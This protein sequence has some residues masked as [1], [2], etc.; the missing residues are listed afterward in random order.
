M[1]DTFNSKYP[2]YVY[3]RRPNNSRKKRRTEGGVNR[4]VD[5]HLTHEHGDDLS[6]GEAYREHSPIDTDD[7]YCEHIADPAYSHVSTSFG[8]INSPAPHLRHV[9]Y[10]YPLS[11]EISRH[12]DSQAARISHQQAISDRLPQRTS[13]MASSTSGHLPDSQYSYAP[14]Q[15][16]VY[17]MQSQIA[18]STDQST[19]N[20]NWDARVDNRG[21]APT[22]WNG[23]QPRSLAASS[24]PKAISY[25]TPNSSQPSTWPTRSSSSISTEVSHATE[26]PFPT[27]NSP[28]YPQSTQM[29]GNYQTT[30]S[31]VPI[32]SG[33]D[34]SQHQFQGGPTTAGHVVPQYDDQSY[35][36]SS[37]GSARYP[38][39]YVSDP[40]RDGHMFHQPQPRPAL[41]RP[42][43]SVQ[44]L[45]AFPQS[46]A[47]STS[48]SLAQ[49]GFLWSRDKPQ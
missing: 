34:A 42:L 21:F 22:N 20:G 12:A 40:D 9:S 36:S 15:N 17:Q 30:S 14:V 35:P 48:S 29:E 19:T 31:T 39:P 33:F 3:R 49:L 23:N 6:T 41:S 16:Q 25:T 13:S 7:G 43:P 44:S 2:D 11:S 38:T 4:G 45:A 18:Y 46:H 24:T 47:H 32:Q 27:L 26:Y 5:S 1:K 10:A 28:F 8:D 37:S